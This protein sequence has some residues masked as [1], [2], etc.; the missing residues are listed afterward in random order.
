MAFLDLTA[1]AAERDLEQ[2]LM[3]RIVD[4][5]RELGTGF[6]FV[7]CQVHFD[8][9]ED[10]FYLDL[11]SSTSLNYGTPDPFVNTL[12]EQRGAATCPRYHCGY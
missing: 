2:A 12:R 7:G 9:A 10:D 11:L 8:V 5:V 4:T 3:D 6:A 1:E